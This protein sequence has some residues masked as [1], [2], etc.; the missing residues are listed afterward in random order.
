VEQPQ[1]GTDPI[2]EFHGASAER[3]VGMRNTDALRYDAHVMPNGARIRNWNM[4][5]TSP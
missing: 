4:G 3:R 5:K 2:H 1:L